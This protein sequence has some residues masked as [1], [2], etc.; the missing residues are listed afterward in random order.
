M[1][2][3]VLDLVKHIVKSYVAHVH[4]VT[5]HFTYIY[6]F[7]ILHLLYSSCHELLTMEIDRVKPASKCTWYNAMYMKVHSV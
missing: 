4:F 1:T 2:F 6:Q 7:S 5:Y 3:M